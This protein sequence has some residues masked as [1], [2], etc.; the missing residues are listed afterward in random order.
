MNNTDIKKLF[1]VNLSLRSSIQCARNSNSLCIPMN[2]CTRDSNGVCIPMNRCA[3][4]SNGFCIPMIQCA[5]NSNSFSIFFQDCTRQRRQVVRLQSIRR[6]LEDLQ[7]QI[8]SL[9][10]ASLEELQRRN[11]NS[12]ENDSTQQQAVDDYVRPRSN[13][14]AS[15][16]DNDSENLVRT[17][18]GN[19]LDDRNYDERVGEGEHLAQLR[20]NSLIIN[21][22]LSR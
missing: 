17:S 12:T 19:L 6:M 2:R 11:S 3:R 20:S 13:A 22:T 4:D 21:S 15:N 16:V 1:L 14:S 10:A 5:R 8:R 7:R 9:R 18:P